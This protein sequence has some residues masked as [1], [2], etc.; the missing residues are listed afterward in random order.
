VDHYSRFGYIHNQKTQSADETLEG[1]LIFERKAAL[2][3]VT[4]QHY[5]ADNGIFVS[6]A[7]KEDCLQKRQGFTYSGVN[8]HFQSG[9]AERRIR[10]VQDAARV[11]LIH[12][13]SRWPEAVSTNLWPYA[14]RTAMDT[15]CEAPL[16]TLND[17]S[18][19]EMFTNGLVKPEPRL[20]RPWGCPT[21]VLDNALQQGKPKAKWQDRSRVGIYIGRSPFHARTVALVLSLTTGRV[22]PQF[23]VQYDPSF[24]TVKKSFGGSLPPSLW[25]SVCGFSKLTGN[26]TESNSGSNQSGREPNPESDSVFNSNRERAGPAPE[27]SSHSR[28]TLTQTN[29]NLMR[30]L[31]LF[32]T[33]IPGSIPEFLLSVPI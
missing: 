29:W 20:W 12:S 15:Y 28:S 17:K 32:S 7:W 6:K 23:H 31:T 16:K 19:V 21:Y 14:I 1:K 24:H 33:L 8:A 26:A 13:Q 3:G 25:Q 27:S 4:V 9:V 22:S 2:Y 5:H 11:M 18:P 10:E 30:T